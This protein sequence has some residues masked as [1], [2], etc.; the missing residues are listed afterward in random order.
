MYGDATF[1]V[2]EAEDYEGLGEKELIKKLVD[3]GRE[4]KKDKDYLK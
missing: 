2:P 3:A 4:G 1:N